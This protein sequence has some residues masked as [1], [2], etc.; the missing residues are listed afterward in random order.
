[1]IR[2]RF[3]CE[4]LELYFSIIMSSFL[5]K[6]SEKQGNAR[7]REYIRKSHWLRVD[8]IEWVCAMG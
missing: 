6:D 7:R 4:N 5:H 2:G 1:M 8:S 3:F